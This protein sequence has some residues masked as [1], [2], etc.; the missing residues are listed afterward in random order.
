LAADLLDK[1]QA[2]Y[3]SA[4]EELQK[5]DRLWTSTH[6]IEPEL[7]AVSSQLAYLTRWIAQLEERQ[8]Q[9]SIL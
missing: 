8:F 2:I 4:L 9:L 6:Q 3:N 7:S 5:L 1:L